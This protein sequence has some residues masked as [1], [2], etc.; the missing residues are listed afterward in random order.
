MRLSLGYIESD[1]ETERWVARRNARTLARLPEAG[2]GQPARTVNSGTWIP[3]GTMPLVRHRSNE[4]RRWVITNDRLS[5]RGYSIEYDLGVVHT[6]GELST[7]RLLVADDSRFFTTQIE[8]RLADGYRALGYVEQ[9]PLPLLDTLELRLDPESN[10]LTL[11][12]GPTDPLY[13]IATPVA[14]LGLLDSYPINPRQR[15]DPRVMWR[16]SALMREVDTT[17][18]RHHYLAVEQPRSGDVCLGGLWRDPCTGFV[19]LRRERDG[20][21]SSELLS[22][23]SSR[24]LSLASAKWIAA[25]LN[26]AGRWPRSW[27]LRAVGSRSRALAGHRPAGRTYNSAVLGYLRSA[28]TKGWAPLFSATHPV[29]GDQYLTRSEIEAVDLGYCLDGVI[30]YIMDAGAARTRDELP[31]EVKW[32]SRFGQHRRYIEGHICQPGGSTN[33]AAVCVSDARLRRPSSAV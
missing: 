32:G 12:A 21:L 16:V 4:S 30:G 7:R 14:T 8:G 24:R 2:V 15:T 27:T 25:P 5:P 23:S 3:A 13:T 31:A 22:P 33:V 26:W 18:W 17:N 29:L 6:A 20:R 9:A 19:P 1:R 11:V 28:P 10:Q